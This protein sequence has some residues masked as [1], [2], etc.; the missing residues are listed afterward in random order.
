MQLHQRL[1][2]TPFLAVYSSPSKRAFQTASYVCQ[3]R[4]L[5]IQCLDG[6][7]EL[8][9]GTMEG[10]SEDIE[11]ANTSVQR[12]LYNWH[13]FGGET[14]SDVT[15][16]IKETLE[17]LVEKHKLENGNI[18]CVSHGF[19]ILAAI[20]AVDMNTFDTCLLNDNFIKNC[21][22]TIIEWEDGIFT[23]KMINQ[24]EEIVYEKNNK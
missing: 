17:K 5:N 3:D 16:R 15:R 11:N 13:E 24:Y 22:I 7:K 19:S 18:L 10:Q 1:L 12:I 6:L 8:H 20:R 23:I 14:I 2:T 21:A 9:F 4:N